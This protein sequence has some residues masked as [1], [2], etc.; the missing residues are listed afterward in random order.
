MEWQPNGHRTQNF[1]I[2]EKS[3][4]TILIYCKN[5]NGTKFFADFGQFPILKLFNFLDLR[6]IQIE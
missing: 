5:K 4:E 2:F 6:K 3:R 1:R